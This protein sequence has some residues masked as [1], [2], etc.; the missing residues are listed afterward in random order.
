MSCPGP[1]LRLATAALAAAIAWSATALP[2]QDAGADAA[3]AGI[4]RPAPAAQPPV[5]PFAV[6]HPTYVPS[7]PTPEE[8]A[9]RDS[10]SETPPVRRVSAHKRKTAVVADAPAEAQDSPPAAAEPPTPAETLLALSV[11]ATP[12]ATS[13]PLPAAPP[14]G[15]TLTRDDQLRL[16]A[17]AGFGGLILAGAGFAFGRRSGRRANLHG[18]IAKTPSWL[19]VIPSDLVKSPEEPAAGAPDEVADGRADKR[20]KRGQPPGATGPTAAK[21]HIA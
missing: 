7:Q 15:L 14:A 9:T 6:V 10:G 13:R 21:R 17:A 20:V 19:A 5:A 1:R 11:P 8:Q 18:V 16:L 12:A 2:A 3:G 4:T